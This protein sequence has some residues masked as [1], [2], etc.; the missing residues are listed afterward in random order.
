MLYRGAQVLIMDEP[1]AV[2]AP[3]EI[4]ELFKTLRSMVAK[5][6][7]SSSSATS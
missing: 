2:L 7:P 4:E 1:T 3:L 5:A 6:N